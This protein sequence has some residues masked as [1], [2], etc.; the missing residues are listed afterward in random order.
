[1]IPLKKQFSLSNFMQE[2]IVS[3]ALVGAIVGSL[4]SGMLNNKF[5]RRLSM[6]IGGFL[7][8]AGSISMGVAS[9]PVLI[10]IGRLLV[11]FGIGLLFITIQ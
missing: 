3:M 9:G 8:T 1:M 10:L 4:V 11:G 2:A 6:M 7:F 5:G